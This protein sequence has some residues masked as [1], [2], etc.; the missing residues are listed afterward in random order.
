V[1]CTSVEQILSA[2]I[3]NYLS[4]EDKRLVDE[5]IRNCSGC[6]GLLDDLRKTVGHTRGLDLIDP[7]PWF[8]KKVMSRLREEEAG[9]KGSVLRRL[10]YLLHIKVPLEVAATIAVVIT[11]VYVFRGIPPEMRPFVTGH[12][13]V[14]SIEE[15]MK[16]RS[17]QK[18]APVMERRTS[19]KPV[20]GVLEQKPAPGDVEPGKRS[21]T[22]ADSPQDA[23]LIRGVKS[24]RY[25]RERAER[26]APSPVESQEEVLAYSD[27]VEGVDRLESKTQAEA[28]IGMKKREE[29]ALHY[30]L[31]TEESHTAIKRMDGILKLLNG[32]MIRYELRGQKQ[33]LV[34]E[35][36]SNRVD[37]FHE[38]LRDV[39]EVKAE[40]DGDEIQGAAVRIRV[41]VLTSAK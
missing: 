5:H 18:A 20:T 24:G 26:G 14:P 40:G 12:K 7:P 10:F 41:E 3:D 9:G 32:K 17:T 23:E 36:D 28:N 30:T 8:R 6:A 31:F 2:Y 38:M 25:Q 37:E 13:E 15:E 33:V 19:D 27:A 34:M 21:L 11:A 35:L 29:L 16:E 22:L 39:G 4:P 1:E